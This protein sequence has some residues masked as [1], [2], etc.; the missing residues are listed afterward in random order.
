MLTDRF[1]ETRSSTQAQHASLEHRLRQL[2]AFGALVEQYPQDAGA[3]PPSSSIRIENLSEAL[4]GHVL[5]AEGDLEGVF[6]GL[7]PLHGTEVE[8]GANGRRDRD[9]LPDGADNRPEI[10]RAVHEDAIEARLPTWRHRDL[11]Q[12]STGLIDS[13]EAGRRAMRCHRTGACSQARG[14]E[15][16]FPRRRRTRHSVDPG[17][18]LLPG[19]SL[20]ATLGLAE[21][22]TGGQSLIVREQGHLASG[23]G[24]ERWFHPPNTTSD[25]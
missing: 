1:R 23:D 6:D 16:L 15:P 11:D 2:L 17:L 3:L 22:I 8:N 20:P 7:R 18:H 12:G 21:G 9:S 4:E 13:P 24:C 25:V 14:Q 10:T 5:S 19:A